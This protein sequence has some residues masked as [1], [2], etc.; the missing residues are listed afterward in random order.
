MNLER[1][2]KVAVIG[3]AAVDL[4]AIGANLNALLHDASNTIERI[5]ETLG[6]SGLNVATAAA[7]EVFRDKVSVTLFT[8]LGPDDDPLTEKVKEHCRTMQMEFVRLGEPQFIPKIL[9]MIASNGDRTFLAGKEDGKLVDQV[10]SQKHKEELKDKLSKFDLIVFA[11]VTPDSPLI[12][13]QFT[14]LVK[15]IM[16]T[17]SRVLFACDL[18]LTNVELT[19]E[20]DQFLELMDWIFGNQ[21]ELT[22]ISKRLSEKH[23]DQKTKVIASS[24]QNTP[25]N[26]QAETIAKSIQNKLS[27]NQIVGIK[28]GSKGAFVVARSDQRKALYADIPSVPVSSVVDSTG[29]GDCWVG[30][31]IAGSYMTTQGHPQNINGACY[32][33][34]IASI[35]IEHYGATTW[36]CHSEKDE[37]ELRKQTPQPIVRYEVEH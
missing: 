28:K 35:C 20:F 7:H 1:K 18:L 6:G 27:K 15:E 23:G 12:S 3:K 36:I 2:K 24:S 21:T 25:H 34:A 33:N 4:C 17:N 10:L 13:L 30:G 19:G 11:G 29:A 16:E 31:I 26:D 37:I 5:S 14:N 8:Q 22:A 9:C 32:G